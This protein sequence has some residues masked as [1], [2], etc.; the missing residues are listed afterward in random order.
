MCEQGL[1][2]SEEV[3]FAQVFMQAEPEVYDSRATRQGFIH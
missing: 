1:A 3:G 2:M